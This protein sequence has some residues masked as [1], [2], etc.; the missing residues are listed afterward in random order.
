MTRS[1]QLAAYLKESFNRTYLVGHWDCIIFISMWADQ[2]AGQDHTS[3]FRDTYT[4]EEAGR[5]RWAFPDVNTAISYHLL[6]AG[7]Q[8]VERPAPGEP[9]S[10]EVGDIVLTKLHHPGIWDGKKI[11]AQPAN[12][13][14]QLHIHPRH[15]SGGLRPPDNIRFKA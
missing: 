4:T 5:E 12:A 14:G 1:E 6:G 11:V 13:T 15:I 7:W 9:L 3:T 10:L 8:K 2:L